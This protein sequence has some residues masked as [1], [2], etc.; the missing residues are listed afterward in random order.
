MPLA[1]FTVRV[2]PAV[3][4]RLQ[5][6]AKVTDRSR[7]SLAAEALSVYLDANEWQVTSIKQATKSL[8][9]GAGVSHDDVE[10]WVKSWGGRR[11][12]SVPRRSTTR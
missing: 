7:S 8:D 12:R 3:K 5:K 1:I 9:R 6:L 10:R 4:K 11:E 2:E